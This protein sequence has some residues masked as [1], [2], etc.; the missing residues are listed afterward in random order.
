MAA[1]IRLEDLV[2]NTREARE[3]DLNVSMLSGLLP[4]Y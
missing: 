1:S 4:D 3:L 2:A